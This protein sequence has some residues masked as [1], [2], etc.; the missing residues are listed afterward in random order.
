LVYGELN[1][2]A[3]DGNTV[4]MGRKCK[5]CRDEI[6]KVKDCTDFISKQGH[7]S[8][9][10]AS[11]YGLQKVRDAQAKKERKEHA[12]RK[13]KFY[14]GD[15]KTRKKAA[16]EA[17]HLY[18]RTRDKDHPCICCG[19]PLGKSYDAG[20][21]LE[22]GNNSILRFHEDNIHAQSVYCNQ[23]KGGDS[24]DYAGRLRLKIGDA[25]VDYLLG[26]KGGTV[27]RTADDY[28]EIERHYKAKL[29]EIITE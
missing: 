17:C 11:S 28:A 8:I 19:R 10:C 13:R 14:A 5:H 18:I 6:P 22:S 26:N 4:I 3:Q 16:K 23:Y 21:F 24:D 9:D 7:C 15:I 27:K 1:R 2:L 20:H 25:R 29:K 12:E